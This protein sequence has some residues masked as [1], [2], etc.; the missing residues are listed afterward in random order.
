MACGPEGGPRRD[1][2]ATAAAAEGP[3][4]VSAAAM[5]R[6]GARADGS[7]DL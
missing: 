1:A 3:A 2:A 6:N 7:L 4:L 5:R